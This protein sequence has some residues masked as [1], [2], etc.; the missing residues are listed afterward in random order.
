ML[1]YAAVVRPMG[2]VITMLCPRFTQQA[3][4]KCFAKIRRRLRDRLID[5]VYDNAP[6]TI[7]E[8]ALVHYRL[9]LHRHPPCSPE[10]NAAEPWIGWSK[11]ALSASSC[12][13]AYGTLV[14]SFSGFVAS[15]AKRPAEV[16]RHRVSDMLGFPSV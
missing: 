16:L 8:N 11:E 7:V 10:M 12:R 3:S 9:Q 6:R 2:R 5:L 15:M 1:F 13:Q 4:A 14:R